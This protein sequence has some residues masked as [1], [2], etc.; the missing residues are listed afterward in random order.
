MWTFLGPTFIAATGGTVTTDGDYKVHSFTGD[1]CFVV[2]TLGNPVGP[3]NTVDYIVVAGGGG[4]RDYFGAGGGAGGFREGSGIASG[5][6]TASPL[7]ASALPVSA[8][9]YPITVGAGGSW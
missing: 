8:T 5:C 7:A 3:S 2:S 4:G 6:Y 1:G 9:T